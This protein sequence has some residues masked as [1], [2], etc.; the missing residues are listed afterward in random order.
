MRPWQIHVEEIVLFERNN[1][2]Q[3]D[4]PLTK[5]EK[6]FPGKDGNTRLVE[7]K[8][9]REKL[10]GHIQQVYPLAIIHMEYYHDDR[11]QDE[12]YQP[13]TSRSGRA[14]KSTQIYLD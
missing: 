13:L 2:K 11:C 12:N 8:S 7:L 1:L 10:L 5:I 3:K 9:A 4:W 14:I 6:N